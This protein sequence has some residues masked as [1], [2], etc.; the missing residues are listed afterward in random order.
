MTIG[1]IYVLISVVRA[2]FCQLAMV[3]MH[4]DSAAHLKAIV[5]S[6]AQILYDQTPTE[7]AG[8]HA[9]VHN[10]SG[11]FRPALRASFVDGEMRMAPLVSL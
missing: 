11:Y 4:R 6:K 9:S 7:I 5:F 10:Q 3:V 8:T 1:H 2:V